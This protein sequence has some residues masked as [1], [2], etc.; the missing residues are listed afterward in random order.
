[1]LWRVVEDFKE[2]GGT[3]VLTTHYMEEAAYLCDELAI[4]DVG[5]IIARGT[6]RSLVDQLGDVQFLEF[7]LDGNV[8]MEALLALAAVESAERRGQRYR[9]RIDRSVQALST[10]LTELERQ[11]LSPVGLRSHQASLDDVFLHL[12]G[13]ALDAAGGNAERAE[14]ER[15]THHGS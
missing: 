14:G 12:T 1:M 10:V 15:A 5:K 11:R 9:F 4:M 7:E 2:Q 13:R 6:P 8:E 3:V